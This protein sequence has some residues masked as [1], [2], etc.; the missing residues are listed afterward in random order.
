SFDASGPTQGSQLATRSVGFMDA[1]ASA[2][3]GPLLR[4]RTHTSSHP[5]QRPTLFAPH[6]ATQ[7]SQPTLRNPDF[8]TH[9]SP[10]TLRPSQSVSLTPHPPH[11]GQHQIEACDNHSS[12]PQALRS[13]LF[14]TTY[15][16]MNGQTDCP[17]SQLSSL[18]CPHLAVL[19]RL[20]SLDCPHSTISSFLICPNL[21]RSHLAPSLPSANHSL[22]PITRCHPIATPS[23]P[24]RHPVVTPSDRLG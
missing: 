19:T 24:R 4:F 14:P 16:L 15:S 11:R 23:P 12:C 22:V 10:L 20:S 17:A 7:T 9:T 13:H 3:T 8:A 1:H 21:H 18:G 2:C 5:P 6:F